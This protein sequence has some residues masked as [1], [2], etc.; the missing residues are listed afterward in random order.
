MARGASAAVRIHSIDGYFL[1]ED[2]GRYEY[3]PAMEAEYAAS[4]LK[5]FKKTIDAGADQPT[6]GGITPEGRKRHRPVQ[7]D[8]QPI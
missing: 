1:D 3:D 8:L 2:A 7:V 4:L 5:A 6:G